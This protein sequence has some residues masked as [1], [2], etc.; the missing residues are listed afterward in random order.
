[1]F[2]RKQT[3]PLKFYAIWIKKLSHT[4]HHQKL[5][6]EKQGKIFLPVKC[7]SF[8][9]MKCQT[10]FSSFERKPLQSYFI[11]SQSLFV[12]FSVSKVIICFF[13]EYIKKVSWWLLFCLLFTCWIRIFKFVMFKSKEKFACNKLKLWLECSALSLV[14]FYTHSY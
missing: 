5:L 9:L 13:N 12:I 3:R 4:H 11:H 2:I 8:K 7:E 6:W 10:F 1:M 14:N